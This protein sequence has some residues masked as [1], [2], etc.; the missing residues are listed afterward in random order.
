MK[1][2][3]DHAWWKAKTFGCRLPC[4]T[5]MHCRLI[6]A[7]RTKS[8]TNTRCW[9]IAFQISDGRFTISYF[10]A[11]AICDHYMLVHNTIETTMIY[12]L[13]RAE[14]I[15]HCRQFVTSHKEGYTQK[16]HKTQRWT[17][18]SR[19]CIEWQYR[20]VH[21]SSSNACHFHFIIDKM[22]NVFSPI[23]VHGKIHETW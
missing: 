13:S 2:D 8:S 22:I 18:C 4:H 17:K 1:L 21:I 9:N 11:T 19:I 5:S 7:R 20:V 15:S 12:Q 23:A 16:N 14:K 6:R 10:C 3:D